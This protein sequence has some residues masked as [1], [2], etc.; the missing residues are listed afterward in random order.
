[1]EWKD[2]QKEIQKKI[3]FEKKQK[4]EREKEEKQKIKELE[5]LENMFDQM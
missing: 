3:N 4:S 5:N 1:L 2:N